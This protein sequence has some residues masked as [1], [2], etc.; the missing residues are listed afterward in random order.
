MMRRLRDGQN[1]DNRKEE[2]VP[3]QRMNRQGGKKFDCQF[4]F[5]LQLIKPSTCRAT[6]KIT[7][8]AL[9]QGIVISCCPESSD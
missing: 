7:G 3:L 4:E 6:L 2:G 5:V 9:E 8:I 1:Y